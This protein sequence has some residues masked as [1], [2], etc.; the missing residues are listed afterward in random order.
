MA[1]KEMFSTF[2]MGIGMVLVVASSDANKLTSS[3][4]DMRIIGSIREGEG[5]LIA[6]ID[7]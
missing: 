4:A 7:N 2:N 5:V 3:H 6:G 1:D